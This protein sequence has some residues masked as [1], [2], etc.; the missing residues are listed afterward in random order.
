MA[1]MT[2][3]PLDFPSNLSNSV[4]VNTSRITDSREIESPK[5]E[6]GE[7]TGMPPTQTHVPSATAGSINFRSAVTSSK[8]P[9]RRRVTL[10]TQPIRQFAAPRSS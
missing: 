6:N 1:E 5:V 7:P 10:P 3:R 4:R 9:N 8:A 2:N